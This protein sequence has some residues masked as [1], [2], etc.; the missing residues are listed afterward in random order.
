MN[1]RN[2]YIDFLKGIAIILVVFGHN[3]QYGSGSDYLTNEL[4]FDNIIFKFIYSFHMPLF[5][6]I[7]GYLFYSTIKKY[8]TKIVIKKKI[9]SLLVPLITCCTINILIITAN[10]YLEYKTLLPNFFNEF[11]N[12][13][14]HSLW[15]LPAMFLSSIIVLLIE[16]I[17]FKYKDLLYIIIT[18]IMM[19]LPNYLYFPLYFYMFPYFVVGYL[20]NKFNLSTKLNKIR[21]NSL[22]MFL[23][24]ILFGVALSFYNYD[25]YIY[26]SSLSILND[27]RQILIDL[28]RFII[29]FLGIIVIVYISGFIYEKCKNKILI[30]I[31]KIGKL[32]IGIYILSCYFNIYVF[33][34]LASGFEPNLFVWII[35]TLVTLTMFYLVTNIIDK[36]PI[37]SK[38]ILGK[39]VKNE[40]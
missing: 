13:L 33:I 7:S 21:N 26:T 1:K 36:V 28:Y 23:L 12:L 15:F 27:K 4:F 31:E 6:I 8:D 20:Y 16:K 40:R 39:E 9:W 11:K 22:V 10:Y 24:V 29:G 3:I 25:S 14:S 35:E 37:L 19:I 38:Y 34:K 5:A 30:L 17:K 18:I 32:S 2:G